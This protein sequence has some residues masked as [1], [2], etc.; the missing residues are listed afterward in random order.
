MAYFSTIIHL[1]ALHC[2]V[3]IFTKRVVQRSLIDDT[4][5]LR[6]VADIDKFL[7]RLDSNPLRNE[8]TADS[9][10]GEKLVIT[11]FIPRLVEVRRV[12][13]HDI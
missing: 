13:V 1:E 9:P 6:N 12:V 8:F 2:L 11:V 3:E 4:S 5:Q 10:R 7:R